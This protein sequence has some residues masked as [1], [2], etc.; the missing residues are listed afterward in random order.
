MASQEQKGAKV[1]VANW[2]KAL[3]LASPSPA[4]HKKKSHEGHIFK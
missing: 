2:G 4:Q 1:H 3:F